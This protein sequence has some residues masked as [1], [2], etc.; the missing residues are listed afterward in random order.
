M[1]TFTHLYTLDPDWIPA[2][3]ER[4]ADAPKAQMR[5]TRATQTWVYFTYAN[6]G[7]VSL[8]LPRA[9]FDYHYP[10]VLSTAPSVCTIS[11]PEGVL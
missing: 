5:V 6:G 4:W 7:G 9:T 8:K 2:K 3:G 10:K 11:L 1:R